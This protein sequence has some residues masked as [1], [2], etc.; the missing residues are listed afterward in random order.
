[1]VGLPYMHLAT[2]AAKTRL[3]APYFGQV[4][5]KAFDAGFLIGRGSE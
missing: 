4:G 3:E 1:M 2:E 5:N